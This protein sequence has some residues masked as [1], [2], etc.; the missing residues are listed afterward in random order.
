M[1]WFAAPVSAA[2][3]R[4]IAGSCLPM[5]AFGVAATPAMAQRYDP[6]ERLVGSIEIM[7]QVQVTM[8]A[9]DN[10]LAVQNDRTSDAYITASPRIT[11]S[12]PAPGLSWSVAGEYEGTRYFSVQS[13]NA[14]DYA[15]QAGLQYRMGGNTTLVVKGL[16]SRNSEGRTSPDSLTGLARPNRYNLS[17]GYVDLTHRFNRVSVR[18][19]FDYA[20]RNYSDNRNNAGEVVDQDFRDR[21]VITGNLILQY[22]I[23]PNFAVFAAGSANQRDYGTRTGPIPPRDSSGYE[24]AL[25]P[26]FNIGHL[27]HGTLRLGYLQQ[28]YKDPLFKD[29]HGF[30]V[31]G[32]LAYYLTPLVTITARVDRRVVETGVLGAA[33]YVRTTA[34][35]QADYEVLRN[36]ILHLEGGN[37]HR[38]FVGIDRKDNRFTGEF[39]ATWLLS[40]RWSAQFDV[41][42]RGQDSSGIAPGREFTENRASVGIVF[43]GL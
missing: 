7:P 19:T 38:N 5:V 30:L 17:E 34:S 4:T 1:D 21:S 6:F 29:V 20:R 41:S 15:L 39:K 35:L 28:D 31:R 26:N 25:G 9:D 14:D 11:I 42:H 37:E 16:Q 43:K 32:E 23:S 13:E 36:V 40:P 33:G 2:T 22:T 24:L 27:M 18:G 3:F 10:V 8:N 12:R